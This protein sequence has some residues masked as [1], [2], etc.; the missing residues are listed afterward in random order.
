M[1][2]VLMVVFVHMAR[3][4]CSGGGVVCVC[5]AA[6]QRITKLTGPAWLSCAA[7]QSLQIPPPPQKKKNLHAGSHLPT[8]SS[9]HTHTHTHTHA[10]TPWWLC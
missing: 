8:H 10:R 1:D 3:V 5:V 7:P 4:G 6:E 9:A 2:L